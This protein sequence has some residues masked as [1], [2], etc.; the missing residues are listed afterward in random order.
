MPPVEPILNK[1]I[2][3]TTM[4]RN[5][6]IIASDSFKGSLTSIQ[7]GEA[8]AKAVKAIMPKAK[9]E[10]IPV[11]DGGEGTVEAIVAGLKGQFIETEVTGPLGMPVKA[12]YGI[13]GETA[14]I[15]M[16][17]AS[18][19]TLVPEHKRNPWITTTY[20]TGELIHD[21]LS[22]GCR[23][24][25]IGI[26]GSATNDAGI[27]MLQALGFRFLDN[28]GKEVG[29][30]GG[31]TGRIVAIETTHILPELKECSFTVACDVTN[32]LTGPNGASHIYSPQKGADKTMADQL[33]ACLTSFANVVT[34]TY[35]E[36]LSSYP[37]AG[38]AGGLGFAFLA[39]L[40]ATL[41]PGIDMVL[42]AVG[43]DAK[44]KDA[45]LVITGEGRLDHQTCMGKTPYGVLKHAQRESVPVITI[46]G[47][48]IPDA[49]PTLM[50]A[51]FKAVFPIVSGPITLSEA[52][53]PET[54]SQNITRTV[55]QILRL[56][57][58]PLS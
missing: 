40:N 15:E 29:A 51:G 17:E 13:C 10:T 36:D 5:K 14:V 6:I 2:P 47:S 58:L 41:K 42:D 28:E 1:R 16:A 54:A 7:V 38:A 25:L 11:A 50:D 22:H 45:L 24:F 44:L 39:F 48:V 27:G 43:F 18:G 33:D 4:K 52:L 56:L 32:P 34:T 30:G 8:A 49:V 31:E 3:N 55:S 9:C 19:L 20:G 53:K 12:V 21:A 23:N 37:G 26:G 46:G 35:G 57:T